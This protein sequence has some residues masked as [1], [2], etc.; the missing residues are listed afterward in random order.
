MFNMTYPQF[1]CPD[2]RVSTAILSCIYDPDANRDLYKGNPIPECH[3]ATSS[4]NQRYKA[5]L[6]VASHLEI[7]RDKE[8]SECKV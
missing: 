5:I 3:Y 7:R 8:R 1:H 2:A 6:T 4:E